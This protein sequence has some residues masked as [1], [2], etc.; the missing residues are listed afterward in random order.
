M[1]GRRDGG[2][3]GNRQSHAGRAGKREKGAHTGRDGKKKEVH[4]DS[5]LC[6]GVPGS[7]VLN[8]CSIR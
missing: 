7:Y 2:T 1:E 8:I 5:G 6:I 3:A 4:C